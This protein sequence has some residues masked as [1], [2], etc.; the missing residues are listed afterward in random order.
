MARAYQDTDTPRDVECTHCRQ[1]RGRP[2][3]RPSGHNIPFGQYHTARMEAF[4]QRKGHNPSMPARGAFKISE[5]AATV[6]GQLEYVT[7]SKGDGVR[8]PQQLERKLYE[9]VNACLER[10]GGKW[11]RGMKAHLFRNAS[12]ARQTIQN[13]LRDGEAPHANPHSFFETPMA[14]IERMFEY[15]R[16]SD[17]APGGIVMDPSCGS[18]AIL[19]AVWQRLGGQQIPFRLLGIELDFERYLTASR[20]FRTIVWGDFL[21]AEAP[22]RQELADRILMNPPYSAPGAPLLW[23]D[24][25]QHAITWLAPGGI[26]VAI[27]PQGFQYRQDRRL[28]EFRAFLQMC[29]GWE[30][31]PADAF[32]ASG[33]DVQTSLLWLVRA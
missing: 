30:K 9:E 14:V 25:V 7:S 18:G 29:G 19:D 11:D 33:T 22:T 32:K 12:G 2:C 10:A 26:L 8:I 5:A 6:L 4:S 1:P 24:H 13:I 31:L 20:R 17:V 16:L 15:G 21:E 28:V 23:L 27:V 3:T